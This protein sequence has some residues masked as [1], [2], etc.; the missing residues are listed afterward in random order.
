MRAK[1]LV[2]LSLVVGLCAL[3]LFMLMCG[4][5]A[6]TKAELMVSS[7]AVTPEG[8]RLDLLEYEP[9]VPVCEQTQNKAPN[10]GFEC[11]GEPWTDGWHESGHDVCDFTYDDPAHDSEVSAQINASMIREDK[12]KLFTS[13][14][15]IDVEGGRW[16]DYSAWV[17]ADLSQGDAYLRVSFWSE[18]GGDVEYEG[19]AYTAHVQDTDSGWV[20][21]T[22][23]V[24]A[25][26]E[27]EYARLEATLP[28]SS[29]GWIRFDDVFLGEAICLE[30]GKQDEPDPV[31]P[32]GKLTYTI[33][34][35]NTGRQ[36]ATDVR[37]IERYCCTDFDVVERVEWSQP[38]PLSYTDNIWETPCL[39]PSISSTITVRVKLR[40]DLGERASIVNFVQIRSEETTDPVYTT[41]STRVV[42]DGH[43]SDVELYLPES[44]K[45]GEPG[46]VT[47]YDL[48]LNNVGTCDGRAYLTATSSQGWDVI[49]TPDPPYTMLSDGRQDVTVGLDVREDA[50]GGITDVTS[51]TATLD[52]G[53]PCNETVTQTTVVTTTVGQQ[54]EASVYLPLVLREWPPALPSPSLSP[55]N[56]PDGDG[57]Y[58]VHWTA[59]SLADS[60]VLE[61]GTNR[62]F[63]YPTVT[64]IG[65]DTWCSISERGAAR[66]YYRVKS[67]S[68]WGD[69]EWSDWEAV[70]VLWELE[71]NNALSDANG[72][73]V[74]RV[75][76]HG[77][78]DSDEDE[79]DCYKMHPDV[80]GLVTAELRDHECTDL[81]FLLYY[82]S[83]DNKVAKDWKSPYDLSYRGPMGWYYIC[84]Y[85][86]ESGCSTGT[87]YMLRATFPDGGLE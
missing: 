12:C 56:N 46:C 6:A 74:R 60:Y 10:P 53:P 37:V 47:D 4:L 75:E 77:R 73:L 42:P 3:L 86:P 44:E 20:Q 13:I 25:P 59:E 69:S 9:G 35:S 7:V 29:K 23:S 62:Y 68:T 36:A 87:P 2:R 72:P 83:W 11:D 52:C 40:D 49:F 26:R 31:S 54:R 58:D 14:H 70:D 39:G 1:I 28:G 61:E 82:E 67:R 18:E 71:P 27:A 76:Y 79:W 63:P 30:I 50:G 55:I 51:I 8:N 33:I 84:I 17:Q 45:P 24:Q 78:H 85:T 43:S 5:S 34:Y 80:E 64:Y 38:S 65:T 66:Y 81:Q 48:V 57:C 16:Y 19:D 32:G 21:V 41:T 15:D 22:G